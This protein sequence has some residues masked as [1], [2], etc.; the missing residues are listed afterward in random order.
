MGNCASSNQEADGKTRSDMI[1]RQIEEDAK[2]YKRE[3]KIL[4]LGQSTSSILLSGQ[5]KKTKERVHRPYG[6]FL[7]IRA[8]YMD[9]DDGHQPCHSIFRTSRDHPSIIPLLLAF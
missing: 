7:S 6:E 1:D 5:R 2:K 9:M 4:L 3:C 8:A